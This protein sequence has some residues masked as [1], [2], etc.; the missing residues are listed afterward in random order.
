[1]TSK[2]SSSPLREI[3]SDGRLYR[4]LTWFSPGF[5]IGAFSYS[6]GLEAAVDQG[7]VHD[8]QSLQRWIGAVITLGA[9]RM[10]AD[11][12]RD[13]HLAAAG[14]D[15]GALDAAN[16]RGLA[17]RATSE[18]ALES[19]A[20]GEAFLGAC[21]AAWPDP[22]HDRWAARLEEAGNA[23]CH[24]AVV[25]VVTGCAGIPLECALT[26]YLH[27]MAANLASAGLRLGVIGQSNGQRI[28]AALEPVVGAAA[29]ALTRGPD[30]FGSATFG[31]D[32]ASIAHET[33]YTRLF[34]S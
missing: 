33:Q 34:R 27:A 11:T 30:E 4:L 18:L 6:H 5:P 9:G 10:D 25:G 2:G 24:A 20:Q 15:L 12:L 1:M 14:R 7:M 21:R 19:K 32:L 3:V 26:A 8:R 29:R 16:Q 17:F 23:V 22:F 28:L 13:A 31:V